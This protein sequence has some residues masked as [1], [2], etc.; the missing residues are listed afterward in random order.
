MAMSATSVSE[1]VV[2]A[3]AEEPQASEASRSAD[4]P[5]NVWLRHTLDQPFGAVLSE[6]LPAG[7]LKLA[8]GVGA[9]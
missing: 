5:L 2:A 6:P 8:S 7:L 9:T 1:V 4:I 3:A